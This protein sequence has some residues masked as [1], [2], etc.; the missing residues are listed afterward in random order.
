MKN[1]IKY[2]NF[3]PIRA[4]HEA[5]SNIKILKP[6]GNYELDYNKIKVSIIKEN[7]TKNN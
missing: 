2:I 4:I 5:I 1:S 6:E 3:S 7:E